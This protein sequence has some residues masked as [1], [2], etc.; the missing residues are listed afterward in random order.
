MKLLA[1]LNCEI[2]H[3]T[4]LDEETNKKRHY[5]EGVFMQGD[6]KNRN[7]R[8]YPSEVLFKETARYT[9]EYVD[10]NRAYGELGHPRGPEINLDRASHRIIS[11][12]AEGSDVIGKA[13]IMDTP[14]G[15][16]AQSLL[17]DGGQLGVS[18]RGMGSLKVNEAGIHEVQKDFMLVTAGDI[19]ADPSAPKAFV[20]D[21]MEG[22]E[23]VY[24]AT[25]NTFTQE[26]VDHVQHVGKKNVKKM[27][28]KFMLTAFENFIKSL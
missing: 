26:I 5:I 8:I 15:W 13:R 22:A 16:I 4:E 17:E 3:K 10:K 21:I 12:K 28:D 9:K 19:V 2:Q 18:S 1:E 14:M 25:T 27:D 11:L 24:N 23:W 6:V 20:R 7:K